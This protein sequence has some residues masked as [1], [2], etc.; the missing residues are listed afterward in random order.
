MVIKANYIRMN[1]FL[2][3]FYLISDSLERIFLF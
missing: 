3:C 2:M 1:Y